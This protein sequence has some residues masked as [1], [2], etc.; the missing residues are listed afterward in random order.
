L[1]FL[2]W[3]Y[4]CLDDVMMIMM[5]V[6]R[7]CICG[8]WECWLYCIVCGGSCAWI[9]GWV[10]SD[11]TLYVNAFLHCTTCV[12]AFLKSFTVFSMLK[13]SEYT[14]LCFVFVKVW[15]VIF[16][17]YESYFNSVRKIQSEKQCK[18]PII[19]VV[20]RNQDSRTKYTPLNLLGPT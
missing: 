8:V 10:K 12:N 7:I 6:M 18:I 15:A 5:M 9:H 4:P 3:G 17:P 16:F 13:N 20:A 19:L 14:C 11:V 1:W 2:G